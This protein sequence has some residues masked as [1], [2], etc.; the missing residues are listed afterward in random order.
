MYCYG[1][2]VRLVKSDYSYQN[3]RVS[4]QNVIGVSLEET[5]GRSPATE[6]SEWF[7]IHHALAN[8]FEFDL[9]SDV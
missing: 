2:N 6:W 4:R 1:V 8:V 7:T 3:P 5:L 9:R